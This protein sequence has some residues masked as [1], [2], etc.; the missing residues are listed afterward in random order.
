MSDLGQTIER[1][2]ATVDA[3]GR[4]PPPVLSFILPIY[5][6]RDTLGELRRRLTAVI[7]Q[8]D[9][10]C[11]II[12]V[13]DGSVDGSFEAMRILQ[14]EDDRF[15]LVRFSRNF[16]HQAAITAGLDLAQGDA[17][18]I[19]DGDLQH[20]P[21]AV[22]LMITRW[23]EG[24]DVV[25]AVPSDRRGD[26]L[27]KRTSAHLFYKLL[28]RVSDV[29][30][31]P[32]AGDFR[33]VDRGALDAVMAMRES[34]RYLRGMF[35]WVGFNHTT[36]MYDYCERVAGAPKYNLLR[37]VRLGVDGITGFSYAPLQAALHLGFVVAGLSFVAGLGD[38]VAKVSN[39]NTV[40]GWLSLAIMV[41]FLGGVQ[42]LVLGVM[43][44]YMARMFEEIKYRPLYVVR[45]VVGVTM[46][47][48]TR[49]RSVVVGSRVR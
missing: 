20:P 1:S 32:N 42:L 37:M 12:M 19:M 4:Q 46:P 35:T 33:L 44:T 38:I 22:P 31:T 3:A 49:P 43:G 21:E 26:T 14:S 34:T 30:V 16:G 29:E 23:R 40:P 24:F 9:E 18:V 39:A 13:D 28:Q 2:G 8:L 11:E 47:Q 6:E 15:K 45:E 10:S 27:F 36:I 48:T 5:N 25:N 17:V 41:S 7:D